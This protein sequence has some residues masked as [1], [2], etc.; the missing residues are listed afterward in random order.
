MD[1]VW[2][3]PDNSGWWIDAWNGIYPTEAQA[4]KDGAG[5]IRRPWV[6]NYGERSITA[7]EQEARGR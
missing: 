1:Y 2:P 3:D 4:R 5:G 6:L 7:D